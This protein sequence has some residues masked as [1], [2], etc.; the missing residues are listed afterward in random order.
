MVTE[1]LKADSVRLAFPD[2]VSTPA[3]RVLFALWKE[4]NQSYVRLMLRTGL[5]R[6]EFDTALNQ[7]EEH[8]RVQR[9]E[10]NLPF[11]HAFTQIAFAR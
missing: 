7:L 9:A 3:E 2:E 4:G 8:G 1:F 5:R 6:G 10:S 11:G